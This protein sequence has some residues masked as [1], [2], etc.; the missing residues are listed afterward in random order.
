VIHLIDA[1]LSGADSVQHLIDAK[2]VQWHPV[3]SY[4]Q[5]ILVADG[6]LKTATPADSVVVDTV[7]K[8]AETLRDNL[9]HGAYP[10]DSLLAAQKAMAGET[11][12]RN[13]Y[14]EAQR[15]VMRRLRNL[16]NRGVK[17]ITVLHEDDQRNPY[18]TTLNK[19]AP[20][21]NKAFFESLTG[22]SSDI[23]RLTFARDD[24]KDAKGDVKFA[25][26]TRFLQLRDS[27]DALA[28]Y[29]VS[30][31]VSSKLPRL[32]SNPSM[33]KLRTIL[34][35]D[36]SWL[37]VYGSPGTGKTS[38]VCSDAEETYQANKKKAK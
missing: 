28:K 1:D 21:V 32:L 26:D 17:I 37:I 38:L 7:T 30:P 2:L 35:K 27:E 34:E 19:R 23:F 24:I 11:L 14:A 5:F 31:E 8:L 22:A 18:E 33:P 6:L 9:L 25:R 36:P 10:D 20:A 15:V 29:H 12:S 16:R 3:A 13:A 4:D